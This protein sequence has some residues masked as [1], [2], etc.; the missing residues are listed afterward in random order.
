MLRHRLITGWGVMQLSGSAA[1]T[2]NE[3]HIQE[4]A[5]TD[6]K[7]RSSSDIEKRQNVTN[8]KLYLRILTSVDAIVIT[9][10]YGK[11]NAVLL[12]KIVLIDFTIYV[13]PLKETEDTIYVKNRQF[14]K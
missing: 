7:L 10:Q 5:S 13:L 11:Y 6:D 14:N 12:T 4:S 9:M 2:G 1:T 8:E 3:R